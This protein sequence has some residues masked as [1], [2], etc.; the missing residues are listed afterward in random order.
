MGNKGNTRAPWH[1]YRM[2]AKYMITFKKA[3]MAPSFGSVSGAPENAYI[4]LT[5]TGSAVKDS[6]R[7]LRTICGSLS[8]WQYII[9]P[10]HLHFLLNAEDILDEPLGI[11]MARLKAEMNKRCGQAI[12]EQG[13]NDQIIT[14]QR[15]LDTIF[16]YL[17]SNPYRLAVRRAYPDYFRRMERIEIKGRIYQA[18]G[19]LQLLDNPFKEQVVVHRA[20]STDE[21]ARKKERWLYTAANGGVLVSP[22]ISKA[23][24]EVRAEAE[25]AYGR[26]ILIGDRPFGEREKPSSPISRSACMEMN[27]LASEI[28]RG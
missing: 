1:D 4:L 11:Y 7:C 10:D 6:L 22:F 19:N 25:A 26:L 8:L 5:K 9:M 23:E 20:D 24:K 13:F 21:L 15:S 16:S 12:F 3:P 28:A 18:Y 17:R 27:K 2:P 14:P